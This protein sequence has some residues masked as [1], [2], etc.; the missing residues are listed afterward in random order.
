MIEARFAQPLPQGH[1]GCHLHVD[2]KFGRLHFEVSRQIT[3]DGIV[4]FQTTENGAN[5]HFRRKVRRVIN[6][7]YDSIADV[8]PPPPTVQQ[9]EIENTAVYAW[10]HEKTG[11]WTNYP[12]KHSAGIEEKI[13]KGECYLFQLEGTDMVFIVEKTADGIFQ[14]RSLDSN[15][16]RAVKKI[17]PLPAAGIA[18]NMKHADKKHRDSLKLLKQKSGNNVID[19]PEEDV[20]DQSV[21]VE[22]VPAQLSPEE[23]E[24]AAPD[25]YKC[26]ISFGLMNDPVISAEG[27]VYDGRNRGMAGEP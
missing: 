1:H 3:G 24:M 7:S 16:T 8:A 11:Q 12:P 26:P 18:E 23:A 25:Q 22:D 15:K 5:H 9:N 19:D 20:P 27:H 6:D 14:Q 2:T 17:Q 21:P 13:Q 4:Y 10:K